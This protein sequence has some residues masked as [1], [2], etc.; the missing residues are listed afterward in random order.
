MPD[1]VLCSDSVRTQQTWQRIAASGGGPDA[2]LVPQ[3]YHADCDTILAVLRAAHA[4]HVA[5]VGHNPGLAHFATRVVATRP[6]H[7][8]FGDYP[9]GA[10][11]VIDFPVGSWRDVAWSTG[12]VVAFVV[13][14][15]LL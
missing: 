13:P 9:T 5:I 1:E 12:D 2:R 7:A 15:E 3:L 4:P 8:R 14:R 6:N 10:T 11:T